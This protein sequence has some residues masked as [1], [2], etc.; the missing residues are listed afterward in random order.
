MSKFFSFLDDHLD[1]SFDRPEE[2][3]PSELKS[4]RGGR[5]RI[6]DAEAGPVV[7]FVRAS[8]VAG[9]YLDWKHEI[10]PLHF[11]GTDQF[12]LLLGGRWTTAR[13]PYRPGSFGFQE[14]GRVYQEHP[15]DDHRACLLLVYGDRRGEPAT[16]TLAVDR[17]VIEARGATE[18]VGA[19]VAG[20]GDYAHPA[21][22]KGVAAVRTTAGPA[23]G[24][25]FVSSFAASAG[26]SEV[27][28][29][30]EGFGGAW[31]D[32]AVGPLVCILRASPNKSVIP[33]MSWATEIMLVTGR[34]SCQVGGD[35]YHSGEFRVQKSDTEVGAVVAGPDGFEGVLLVAD[36]RAA[37]LGSWIPAEGRAWHEYMEVLTVALAS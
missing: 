27:A 12:R 34:G 23:P 33:A 13:E 1:L 3:P 35:D 26:W 24:G 7:T 37:D 30:V 15:G 36:R 25:H 14:S 29:G 11:H 20:A 10:D 5:F 4:L 28:E 18:I 31:G 8:K 2:W 9:E 32:E 22:R 16:I 19:P 17:D 6:G 21:G